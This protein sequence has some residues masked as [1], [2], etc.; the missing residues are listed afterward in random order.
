M[1]SIY[2]IFLKSKEIRLA[3]QQ[4]KAQQYIR[5]YSF[6]ANENAYANLYNAITIEGFF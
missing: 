5:L 1:F 2:F 3:T 4:I 6:K